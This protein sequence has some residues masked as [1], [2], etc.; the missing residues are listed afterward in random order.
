MA[1]LLEPLASFLTQQL[2]RCDTELNGISQISEIVTENIEETL[3]N[4]SHNQL[5]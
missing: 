3:N 1:S 5:L 2:G 4:I